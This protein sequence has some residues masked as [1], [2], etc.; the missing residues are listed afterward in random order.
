MK[1]RRVVLA[2]TLLLTAALAAWTSAARDDRNA[3]DDKE[4]GARHEVSID[5][6]RFNPPS[7]EVGA[8]E[9]VV[10]IN[11]DDRDH[12]VAADDDSFDSG[13]IGAGESYKHTFD[14][15]GKYSYHC[16]YHPRMKGRVTVKK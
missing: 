1:R 2:T 4:N 11:N 12:T 14:K 9:T 8:G 5:D 7:I 10:W 13:K 3:G 15:A 6:L 16:A